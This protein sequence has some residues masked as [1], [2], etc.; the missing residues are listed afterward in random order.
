MPKTR[1]KAFE[2]E[3]GAL[4]GGRRYW[5]NSGEA[6]DCEG[7]TA[8]A[9]CKY[10]QRMSLTELEELAERVEK[11][12]LPKFKAGLVIVK[13]SGHKGP[14]KARTLVVMTAEVWTQLHGPVSEDAPLD[15]ARGDSPQGAA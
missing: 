15:P 3:A 2:R 9:Q 11:E 10:V 14:R 8:V 1:W 7:P 4:I 12:A 13:R 5:A 6:L